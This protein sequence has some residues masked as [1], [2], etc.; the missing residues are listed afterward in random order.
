[1]H[2]GEDVIGEARGIRV[3]LLDPQ[4][5]TRGEQPVEDV[6]GVAHA[7]VDD[8]GVKGAYWSEMWV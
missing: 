7:D 1:M 4:S 6:G 2:Q 3:V 8:L 5:P